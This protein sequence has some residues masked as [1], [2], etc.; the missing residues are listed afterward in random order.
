MPLWLF[1]VLW[2]LI[3][4]IIVTVILSLFGPSEPTETIPSP[5]S[6]RKRTPVFDD[7][8][9]DIDA[10]DLRPATTRS[11]KARSS[12]DMPEGYYILNRKATEDAG[13]VPKY[14]YLGKGLPEE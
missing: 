5:I 10:E 11:R 9:V 13:G 3:T 12:T 4:Y 6:K 1:A 8:V 7:D 14:I 2:A